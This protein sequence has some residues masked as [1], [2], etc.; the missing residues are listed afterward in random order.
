VVTE[1]DGL[2]VGVADNVYES[3]ETT[4][5]VVKYDPSSALDVILATLVDVID[6]DAQAVAE[7]LPDAVYEV[8]D[9][10]EIVGDAVGVPVIVARAED[11]INADEVLLKVGP[12]DS[13]IDPDIDIVTVATADCEAVD[14]TEREARAEDDNVA[15]GV[16]VPVVLLVPLGVTVPTEETDGAMEAP[17]AS[18]DAETNDEVVAL[19]VAVALVVTDPHVE[20]VGDTVPILDIDNDAVAHVDADLDGADADAETVAVCESVLETVVV[21][22]TVDVTV[23]DDESVLETEA[24]VVWASEVPL[25]DAANRHIQS[26]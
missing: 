18:A 15:V 10:D 24:V 9:D 6:D 12:G 13:V 4:E 7:N 11:D 1:D 8:D 21:K 19:D 5:F 2:P 25:I 26:R 23:T 16:L 14:D 20:L 22:L 17:L 3:V